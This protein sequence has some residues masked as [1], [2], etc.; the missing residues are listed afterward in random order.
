MPSRRRFVL[1]LA[2]AL[3]AA[4]LLSACGF[5]LRGNNDFAFKRLYINLPQNSQMRAQLRRLIDN[6]S[7]TVVVSD[8]QDADAFLDVLSENRVKTIS[9]LTPQGVVREY[10]ITYRFSFQ[11]RD[12]HDNL[13]IPPSEITL[14]RDLSYNETQVLAKDYEEAALYRDM[15]GDIVN[16][17]VRRLASVRLPS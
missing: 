3:P 5:H 17:L 7:D 9:S 8:K 11:L 2:A 16:Q 14:F 6:G 10:R 4:G 15:Q 12:A 13:L 1:A